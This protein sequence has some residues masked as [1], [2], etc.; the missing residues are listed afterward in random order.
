MY[1]GSCLKD[2]ASEGL[3]F[4][5]FL[6]FFCPSSKTFHIITPCFLRDTTKDALRDAE[7]GRTGTWKTSQ[8]QPGFTNVLF[9]SSSAN[10]IF[11][12]AHT[13]SPKEKNSNTEEIGSSSK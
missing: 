12:L 7:T 13:I 11:F 4:N 5:S 2:M 1:G 6:G 10:H 9:G 8:V 3:F